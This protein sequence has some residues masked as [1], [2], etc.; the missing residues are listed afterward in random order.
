MKHTTVGFENE[1]LYQRL[2]ALVI[3]NLIS[4]VAGMVDFVVSL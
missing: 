4:A 3:R 2:S 1:I